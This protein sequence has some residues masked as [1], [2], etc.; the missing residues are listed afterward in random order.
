[1]SKIDDINSLILES[2]ISGEISTKDI[3]D[4]YHTFRELYKHRTILFAIVC[5]AYPEISWKSKKHFEEETD[6][7]FNDD[8]IAGI[9]T[10]KGPATYHMKLEYWN[11]FNIPE[12]ERAYPY[13]GHNS[14]EDLN[15]LLSLININKDLEKENKL[16]PLDII[17]Y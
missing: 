8:F 11:L 13:D 14:D 17:K 12:I 5:N 10:P 6:P 15:R 9:N 3:S 1:M 16:F 7:M 2:K 4:V